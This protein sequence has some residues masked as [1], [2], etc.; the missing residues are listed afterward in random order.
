MSAGIAEACRILKRGWKITPPFKERKKVRKKESKKGQKGKRKEG[1]EGGRKEGRKEGR[2]GG[3]KGGREEGRKREG[4]ERNFGASGSVRRHCPLPF[5]LLPLSLVSSPVCSV[6]L[7]PS[8]CS[9]SS[10]SFQASLSSISLFLSLSLSLCFSFSYCLPVSF[11]STPL[12]RKGVVLCFPFIPP[13][14][15]LFSFLSLSCPFQFPFLSLSFPL[16]FPFISPLFPFHFPLLSF[17]SCRLPISSPHFF[18]LPCI[19]DLSQN[20]TIGFGPRPY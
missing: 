5:L 15:P 18:A 9:P 3:R 2:K 1:T 17:L 16:C 10:P 19:Y 6:V 12:Y 14:L 20:G 8:L 13:A 7:S 11:L 4:K